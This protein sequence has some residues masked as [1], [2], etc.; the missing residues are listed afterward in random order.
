MDVFAMTYLK[1]ALFD[2]LKNQR[3]QPVFKDKSDDNK[4]VVIVRRTLM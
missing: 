1:H 3:K 2:K 4:K